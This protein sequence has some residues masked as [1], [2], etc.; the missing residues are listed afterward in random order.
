MPGKSLSIL[1]AGGYDTTLPAALDRPVGDLSQ[2]ARYLGGAIIRQGH[3]L[4][5]GCQTELDKE[6]ASAAATQLE[7]TKESQKDGRLVSYVLRGMAPIHQFGQIIQSDLSDWDIGGLEPTEP[8]VIR[9]ADVVVLLGGFNGTLQAANWARLRRKPILP[10]VVFGGASK[11]VFAI[12]SKRFDEHYGDRIDRLD[13]DKVL[14]SVAPDWK[15]LAQ[16]TVDLAERIVTSPSVFVVMSYSPNGAFRDLYKSIQKV[17]KRFDYIA[18]RV[19]QSN[20]FKRIVPEILKQVRQC[21]FVVADVTEPKPNVFYEL[22][23]A[24][25]AT[26]DVILTAKA[27][28]QLPFDINDAPV[29]FWESLEK[30]ESDLAERVRQVGA[31]QGRS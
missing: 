3:R 10:F 6:V 23:F 7:A 11:H 27:G 28:T 15:E 30:F 1:I 4:I 19:D 22:G 12:E 9:Y 17:C 5:T 14:K 16:D 21:A 20:H 26:K 29:I 25:G 24:D 18:Q 8:E 31:W 13:Y 2:F